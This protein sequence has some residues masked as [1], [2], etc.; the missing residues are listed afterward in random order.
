MTELITLVRPHM[1]SEFLE[2]LAE[3]TVRMDAAL[4]AAVAAKAVKQPCVALRF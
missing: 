1:K 4:S 3:E 2:W